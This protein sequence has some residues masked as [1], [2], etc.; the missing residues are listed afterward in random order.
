ME[1]ATRR[2]AEHES[3][4]CKHVTT[5]MKRQNCPGQLLPAAVQSPG[6]QAAVESN[7]PRSTCAYQNPLINHS[8][9]Q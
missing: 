7:T 3:V 8:A 4:N 5:L 2:R 6:T 9:T 1:S